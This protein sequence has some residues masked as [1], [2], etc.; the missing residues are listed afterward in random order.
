MNLIVSV[1]VLSIMQIT[2]SLFESLMNFT[3]KKFD[4]LAF[5]TVP[6]FKMIYFF[7]CIII[8]EVLV[9]SGRSSKLMP[10]QCLLNFI[11]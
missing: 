10:K 1:Q 3:I 6:T 7:Y 9:V 4:E 5:Q 11:L 8:G 2:S